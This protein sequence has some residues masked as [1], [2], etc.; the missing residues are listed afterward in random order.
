MKSEGSAIPEFKSTRRRLHFVYELT[1]TRRSYDNEP[2]EF[3]HSEPIIWTDPGFR[4]PCGLHTYGDSSQKGQLG[5]VLA[6]S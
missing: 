2:V 6:N 1:K 4:T 3:E 5:I